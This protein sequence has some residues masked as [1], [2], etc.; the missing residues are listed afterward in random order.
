MTLYHTGPPLDLGPL[1]SLFYF[2][3]SGPDSL[4]LDPFNQ[5][6]QF[7]QGKMIRIFSLTLPGHE[8]N[9]PATDAMRIWAEDFAKGRNP[10]ASFLEDAQQAIEWAIRERF[11]DP[12]K[13]SVAGLSR[14]G[15]VAA[16]LAAR[17][18]RFRQLLCF[19]PVTKLS[20]IR[21]FKGIPSLV[22]HL[23]LLHLAQKLSDRHIKLYI[24][25][26]DT[27]VGTQECFEFAMHIVKKKVNRSADVEL[28]IYPSIG[29]M[30]HGTPPEIFQKGA[31]A[32]MQVF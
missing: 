27:R 9:L 15:F 12:H 11:I 30:G 16:H 13:M 7:L 18:T 22:D 17:E 21:E 19:A 8:N 26:E 23:D 5:I 10:I 28:L 31:D 32:I 29:Q 6:V 4:C 24:G 25:N 20:F 3:L 1:P 2:A 14:G